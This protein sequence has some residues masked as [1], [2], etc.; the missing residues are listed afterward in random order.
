LDLLDLL[1]EQI[2]CAWSHGEGQTNGNGKRKRVCVR[3]KEREKVDDG[4]YN[5]KQT[6]K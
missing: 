4:A 3:K 1:L 2:D 6:T 5:R